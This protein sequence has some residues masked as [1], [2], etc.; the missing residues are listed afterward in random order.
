MNLLQNVIVGRG[1][2]VNRLVNSEP[3]MCLTIADITLTDHLK[4]NYSKDFERSKS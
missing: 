4:E 2:I 3:I 1:S